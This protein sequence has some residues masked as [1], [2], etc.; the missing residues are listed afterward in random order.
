MI[1][2][3]G[4]AGAGKSTLARALA[5][6]L[7]FRYLDTGAMYRC[8][9]L[10]ARRAGIDPEA[11]QGPARLGELARSAAIEL[12]ERILL[13]GEDV[14][15]AIRAPEVSELASVVAAK[16]PV[17]EALVARQRQLLDSG[18]WVAEGRDIGQAV[19]PQAELKIF[20]T[21][22]AQVRARRR[23]E[24]LQSDPK[25]VLAEQALRD[26][27]DEGRAA[28]PL[29]PSADAVIIDGS[30]RSVDQLVAEVAQLARA[31]MG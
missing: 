14:T 19:A 22:S 21:A 15:A 28:S 24:E 31:R 3:D 26:A 2:I 18:D 8:V 1:A 9:A 13:D 29:E 6:R 5:A 10:A 27:R 11:P 25:Q 4:P 30:E 12:G 7:G 16:Q 17:R 20:L 23:A